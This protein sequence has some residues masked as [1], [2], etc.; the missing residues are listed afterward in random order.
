MFTASSQHS[1]PPSPR[2]DRR[3]TTPIVRWRREV[4][5][6]IRSL[7]ALAGSDYA[8]IVTATVDE[9]P[10]DPDQVVQA[11]LKTLPRGL[12]LFI[13]F[14]QRVFLGLCLQLRPSPD[15]LLGWKIAERGENWIR[16]ESA[17]WFLT[18]HVVMHADNGV[19]SL[20]SFIRYDR[21]LAAFVWPPVSL[22]HRQV[23]IA[24]VRSAVRAQ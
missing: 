24:L 18:G 11:V 9:T 21:R 13:A 4:P 20:A 15:Y 14:V 2:R 10:T 22:V 1:N 19:L 16:I 17:S 23:A 12:V 6:A 3:A 7:G 8:D 5:E